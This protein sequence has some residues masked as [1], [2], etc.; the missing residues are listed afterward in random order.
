MKALTPLAHILAS[1]HPGGHSTVFWKKKRAKTLS[2]LRPSFCHL[3]MRQL[4]KVKSKTL[5]LGFLGFGSLI[6]EHPHL[7]HLNRVEKTGVQFCGMKGVVERIFRQ[8]ILI[9]WESLFLV[10]GEATNQ[11]AAQKPV[12]LQIFNI[13]VGRFWSKANQPGELGIK[14]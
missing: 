2:N 13:L 5:L 3:F 6:D 9:G 10:K 4:I 7:R 1:E 8:N 12:V 14:G 11:I